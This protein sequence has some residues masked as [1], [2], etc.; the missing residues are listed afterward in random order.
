MDCSKILLSL[1]LP[2]FLSVVPRFAGAQDIDENNFVRYTRLQGLSNNYISGIVQDSTGYVWIATHKGLNRF[3]GRNFQNIFK[4]SSFSP[5]PDN[6]VVTMH[7]EL[8]NEIIGATRAGGFA[9]DPVTGNSR[10]FIVPCDSTIY[11]WTNHVYDISKDRK[12]NY[13][14]STKTGLFV[15]NRSGKLIRRYDHYKLADVGK[16]ELNFGG[17]V[18]ML[19]NGN[20]LQQNG[21]LGSLY[22]PNTNRIDTLFVSQRDYL[23]KAMGNSPRDF[24]KKSWVGNMGELFLL[25]WENGGIDI[26]DLNTGRN[27]SNP[28]PANVMADLGWKSRL[29]YLNDSLFAITCY[30]SGFYL[31]R[32]NTSTQQLQSD[33]KKYFASRLCTSVLKD[34]DGRLWIGTADGLF[35]QNMHNSFFTVTDLSEQSPSFL[36]HQI[37]SIQVLGENIFAGLL[38][39]GGLAIL[40]KKTQKVKE[41]IRFNP[42]GAYSNSIMNMIDYD[43]DTLWIGTYNGIIWFNI[44]N[45]QY[46]K[47]KMP[48]ELDWAQRSN[49]NCFFMDSRRDVWA[50][51]GELNSLVRYNRTSHTFTNIS[52]PDN[53]LLKV[54]FVFS[55]SE[56]M[57][58][59]VWLAGDGLCRYNIKKQGV[60]TLIPFPKVSRSLRNYMYILA[61][62]N[63]NN[64]W[65]SSF[66]NEIIQFNCS[67]HQM[68]L[69]KQESSIVDGNATT[70]SP[71]INNN[72]WVGTDNGITAFNIND[73]SVK[74]YTYADGLPSVAITS[75]RKESFYD[76]ASNRFYIGAM[77]R[78][79]SFTPNIYLSHKAPPALFIEKI[80]VRDSTILPNGDDLHLKYNQNNITI[81]F[82]TINFTDP[83]DNRYAWRSLSDSEMNWIDLNDQQ[84]ITLTNVSGGWHSVQVKLF[85]VNNHWPQVVK[86]IRFHIR[87]PFWRRTWFLVL[88]ALTFMLVVY[89]LFHWRAGA[90]RKKERAKTHI[91]KLK[92]EEY[93]YQFELEQ[94][95]NYFSSSLAGKKNV[96]AVLWDVAKNL[97]G[98]MNYVDCMIYLW[99]DDRTKMIQK[100]S[101]GPKGTP[102]AIRTKVFDVKPGQGVVGHVMIT[103][104]PLLIADTRDDHRYRVDD[105]ARLSELCVPIIHNNELIG[106]IDSEH[107]IENYF[108][109]RD[110]KILTTIATLVGNKIKQIES[111][112]S[113]EIK[114]KEIA[115]INQQ[116]AE[117][118][119]SALQTQMNPHFIFNSLNSIKGMILVNE[120][121]KA[122]RYL[123]KFAHMIRITLNQ[124]KEIFTTLY[125]NIE[126]LESYLAMEKLRFDSFNFTITVDERIDREETLIPT[127][128]I[129]PL[130]ENAIWH[131]LMPK[132]GEK[133]LS[134]HFSQLAGTISCIIEDN[135]I[136]IN[137]SRELK[138]M[139]RTTH[140]SVGLSNLRNRIKIMNEKYDMGCSLEISD[141]GD[142]N[143]DNAG[144][145]VVLRFNLITNKPYV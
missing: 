43:P 66:D 60:D 65:L 89:I 141:L 128:M 30:N 90:I 138:Q 104:E 36:S 7:R 17:W 15:F 47:V 118:Q 38:N 88:V 108:K 1:L 53:P 4:S 45:H 137:R 102:I 55:M 105:I 82:N 64:L 96:D 103:L 77:H 111:E 143:K 122:S 112:Q 84:S 87:P 109:E 52:P 132:N 144:T 44:R 74:Q 49:T 125:E 129:Q 34:A 134:I 94:I 14:L 9:L 58:G 37:S 93:K 62:D 6:L 115:S 123:S 42:A 56:D 41:Q 63:Y 39:E 50:S 135:G 57:D 99:N 11:F 33:G 131:G 12:G 19:E 29:T 121:Q 73:Y 72:I 59:N 127:M 79:I 31:F 8:D 101:Y 67:S 13:I 117:A 71:I 126:H 85:S 95:S 3:D 27:H 81:H 116:L 16:V 83:E 28:M 145:C 124:S 22:D 2:G 107:H 133:K 69:R 20:T 18:N 70:S 68:F 46:G 78:L 110:I 21:L 86:T 91:E 113:L 32:Y 114:Q 25:N 35:R 61:R 76:K 92:A 142:L 136:G 119:L 54:T 51:F 5:L 75:I 48:P 120:R 26:T 140:Q 139:N 100:A 98:R 80:L 130:A 106:I 40:D 97:I 10:Q 24:I 23:K